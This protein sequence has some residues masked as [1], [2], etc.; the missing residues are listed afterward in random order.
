MSNNQTAEPS[1]EPWFPVTIEF[2]DGTTKIL[3][4]HSE[5]PKGIPFRILPG[6]D[7]DADR[8]RASGLEGKFIVL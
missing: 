3:H 7:D 5:A 8:L 2:E 1:S 4:S 6:G